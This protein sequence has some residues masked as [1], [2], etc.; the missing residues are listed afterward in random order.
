[1][2]AK[3][4]RGKGNCLMEITYM[5]FLNYLIQELINYLSC[6]DMEPFVFKLCLV[7]LRVSLEGS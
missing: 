5:Q 6:L 2:V 1:M 7:F 4:G 3:T